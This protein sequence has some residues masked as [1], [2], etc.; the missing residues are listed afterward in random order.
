M[1]W[2]YYGRLFDLH[3]ASN[4]AIQPYCCSSKPNIERWNSVSK[5]W[6][7]RC[8]ANLQVNAQQSREMVKT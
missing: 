8:E 2:Y 7:G 1:Q 6:G 5:A 4:A 3:L